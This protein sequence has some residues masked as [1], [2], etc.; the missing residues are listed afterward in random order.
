VHLGVRESIA[1]AVRYSPALGAAIC[2]R[3]ARGQSMRAVCALPGMP[4]HGTIAAW[5]R[6]YPAFAERYA[7]A[8]AVRT[9][10]GFRSRG[11]RST[12]RPPLGKAICREIARG[13]PFSS[14]CA[15]EGMPTFRTVRNWVRHHPDFAADYERAQ[16]KQ[17]ELGNRP[18]GGPPSAYSPA[19][20][21]RICER[22]VAGQSLNRICAARGMPPLTTLR[23]WLDD[24]PDFA[25]RFVRAKTVQAAIMADEV[26]DIA[27]D[28]TLEPRDKQVRIGARQWLIGRMK[29]RSR[30]F[31]PAVIRQRQLEAMSDAE[32]ERTL[33]ELLRPEG[34]HPQTE[35][36]R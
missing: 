23:R 35:I 8:C 29:V 21:E 34:G 28:P 4:W 32:L 27:D 20:V 22:I 12:Y 10:L 15:M 17:I 33:Q 14:I 31:D 16:R 1:M 2:E 6:R 18:S 30:K 9:A 26:L 36:R 5:R 19:L 13:R 7:A 25:E 3:I 11:R 24:Y